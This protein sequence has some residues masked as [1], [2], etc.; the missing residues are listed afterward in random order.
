MGKVT[1][2]SATSTSL[3][4]VDWTALT[5]DADMGGSAITSYHLQWD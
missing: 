1:R 2:G 4:E 5:S 3:I